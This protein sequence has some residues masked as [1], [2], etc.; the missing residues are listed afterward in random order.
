MTFKSPFQLNNSMTHWNAGDSVQSYLLP[1]YTQ[2]CHTNTGDSPNHKG[3]SSQWTPAWG[4]MFLSRMEDVVAA[5]L[6]AASARSKA[7]HIF[8]RCEDRYRRDR[9]GHTDFHGQANSTCTQHLQST[10]AQ[11]LSF[12]NCDWLRAAC[13]TTLIGTSKKYSIYS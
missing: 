3:T 2:K 13:Q 7:I 9:A 11:A 5:F 4:L 6:L 8:Q 1:T 10:L 12:G